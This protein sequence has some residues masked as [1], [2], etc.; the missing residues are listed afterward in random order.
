MGLSPQFEKEIFDVKELGD[1][2][3]YGHLMELA[4][5]LWRYDLQSHG[6]PSIGAF[7]PVIPRGFTN[8]QE[9][10]DH[11][12]AITLDKPKCRTCVR[13]EDENRRTCKVCKNFNLYKSKENK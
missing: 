1:R 2:I 3:G 9:R 11:Y 5:A 13:F 12:V 7:V 6:H 10:Y 4:S 8:E